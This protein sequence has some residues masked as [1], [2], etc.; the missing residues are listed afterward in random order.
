MQLAC[1]RPAMPMRARA[2][3]PV[4]TPHPARGAMRGAGDRIVSAAA[5]AVLMLAGD[6]DGRRPERGG[7]TT[8]LSYSLHSSG[9]FK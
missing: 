3:H 4:E 9:D 7:R 2:P 6:G 8:A 5:A 1:G